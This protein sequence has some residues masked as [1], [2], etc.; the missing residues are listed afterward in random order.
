MK[1]SV[2]AKIGG[3]FGGLIIIL[4]ILGGI[5]IYNMMHVGNDSKELSDAYV[6]GITIESVL[7]RRTARLMYRM[8]GYGFTEDEEFYKLALDAKKQVEEKLKIGLE[9]GKKF[10]L[11]SM[12]DG[13]KKLQKTFGKY[14]ELM[15]ETKKNIS[16]LKQARK[17]LDKNAK[18]YMDNCTA[19]LKS[20]DDNLIKELDTKTTASKLKERHRKITVVND[21]INIGNATRVGVFKAQATR[22]VASLDEVIKNFDKRQA[23]FKELASMT[24]QEDN[25]RQLAATITAADSYIEAVNEVKT[26][27]NNLDN[28]S[29]ERGTVGDDALALVRELAKGGFDRTSKIA[30]NATNSL[31]L[32][33]N[34][35]ITGLII[36]VIIGTALAIIV[37]GK[38]TKPVNKAVHIAEAVARGDLS[39]RLNIAATDEIGVL[40]VAI[41]TMADNISALVADANILSVAVEKGKIFT[42]VDAS[43][44]GG[45][46]GKIIKSFNDTLA[47][48]DSAMGQVS[49]AVQQL[50]SGAEQISDA[51]QSL[52]QGATEQASSLEEITSSMTQIGSQTKQNAENANQANAL[53]KGAREAAEQGDR[54]MKDMVEAMNDINASSQQIA[55]VNKVI[56]DIAFQT[57]LLA[58]NAA[59]EAARAGRHGKGFA[60]VADE[61]RNLAGRSAKAAKETAEM[62]EASSGKV[63]NGLIVAKKTSESFEE[64]VSNIIKVT[65]ISGEIAAASNEQAQGVT[66]IGQGLDQVDQVTQENTAN[67]EETASVA[68]ELSSQAIQ[69]QELVGQF[70]LSKSSGTGPATEPAATRSPNISQNPRTP[71]P[72]DWGTSSRPASSITLDYDEVIALDDQDFGKY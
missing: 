35:L 48:I 21:I 7:E 5:A 68:E 25:K 67:A 58:L 39:Q 29:E 20:Q 33:A 37:T 18:I 45:D 56:D 61:V 8:R 23:M 70:E 36:A 51:S 24:R 28:L 27:W 10:E 17:K 16:K 2:G 15:T 54:K 22:D 60:V 52:S 69:L 19:F 14:F 59:V 46:Y 49:E 31:G 26:T 30:V 38:I 71:N 41:D 6:P 64:I 34:V 9:H 42:R 65:D 11:G 13:M 44:H 57:N 63:E 62:I 1:M 66:Q 4:I 47:T 50:T 32:A 12:T 72:G 53:A 43:K 55:K 3:G 40:A